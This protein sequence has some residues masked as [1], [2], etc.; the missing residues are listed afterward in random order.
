MVPLAVLG[1]TTGN[2]H[3]F[4]RALARLTRCYVVAP[5]EIQGSHR[6]IYS[7]GQMDSYEGLVVCYNPQGNIS[8]QRRYPSLSWRNPATLTARPTPSRE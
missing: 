5:T 6:T 3:A 7:H 1:V 2:G 8:W 4:L